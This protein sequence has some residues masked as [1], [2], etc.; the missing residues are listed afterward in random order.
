MGT[1]PEIALVNE[2]A[3][4]KSMIDIYSEN[5]YKGFIMDIH[6]I[7]LARGSEE[8]IKYDHLIYGLGNRS[9]LP[10]IWA[11]TILFQKFQQYIHGDISIGNYLQYINKKIDEGFDPLP[12]YSNDI[13]IF[14]FKARSL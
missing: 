10:V 14:D 3:F 11:D 5:A 8:K 13:E 6:N 12:I 9:E 2:M 4:S 1:R 7:N